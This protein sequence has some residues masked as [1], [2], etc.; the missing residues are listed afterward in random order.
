M[1][2]PRIVWCESG[3]GNF[4]HESL[5]ELL[6]CADV[7]AGATVY[8]GEAIEPRTHWVDADEVIERIGIRA[9]DEHG[10]HAEDYPEVSDEA[11][12]ELDAFLTQWQATHCR[13]NFW[14]V[15]N[16][17][18]HTVTAEELADA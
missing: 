9:Y 13:A 8:F 4:C 10:E 11:K 18:P 15:T 14:V 3:D 7:E 5:E 2:E 17:Q 12:A 16:V 6:G 1:A